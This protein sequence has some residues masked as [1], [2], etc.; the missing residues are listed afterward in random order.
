MSS[1]FA[2]EDRNR[3]RRAAKRGVY[4]RDS[5][6]QVIDAAWIGHIGFHDQQHGVTVI[7]MMHARSNDQLIFHGATTS[8]LMQHLG[9]G[10]P[11]SVSFGMVDGLVLAKSLFHHSMNYRSAVVFG[12]GRISQDPAERMSALKAISDKVMPGRWD[13]A[14]QPNDQEL[15]ATAIV[16]L[17]IETTSAKI[18]SGDPIDAQEDLQLP[19]WS[20]V[21]PM[22]RQHLVAEADK[23]SQNIPLPDYLQAWATAE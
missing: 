12:T 13:D 15:K 22:H 18:R 7:P 19:C 23:H 11:I 4:D 16:L 8:R 1:N 9:S 21:L 5:V 17:T 3:V 10:I 2:V 14:R 6:F 20:G